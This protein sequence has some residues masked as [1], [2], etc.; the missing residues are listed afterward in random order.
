[1]FSLLYRQE[2]MKLILSL[3]FSFRV[4]HVAL[5]GF[6]TT[7]D[8]SASVSQTLGLKVYAIIALEAN[9]SFSPRHNLVG[10]N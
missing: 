6:K 9:N 2:E 1:M 4:T 5:V 3:S 7:G 8:S 10:S